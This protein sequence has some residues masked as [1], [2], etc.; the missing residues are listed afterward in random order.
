MATVWVLL[1]HDVWDVATTD[2]ETGPEDVS[3]AGVFTTRTAAETARTAS[4]HAFPS[5]NDYHTIEEHQLKG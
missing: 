5:D 2:D 1:F 4:E 3:I